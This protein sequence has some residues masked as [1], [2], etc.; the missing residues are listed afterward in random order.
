M[1]DLDNEFFNNKN[2]YFNT[3]ETFFNSQT[4]LIKNIKDNLKNY[5]IHMVKACKH[6]EGIE[7]GFQNYLNIITKQI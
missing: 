4:E 7:N 2:N 5:N 6:S 3:V 1:A